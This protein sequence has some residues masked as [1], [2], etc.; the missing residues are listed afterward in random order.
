M[1]LRSNHLVCL[2]MLAKERPGWPSSVPG[3]EWV[4]CVLRSLCWDEQYKFY[5]GFNSLALPSTQ[6]SRRHLFI[7]VLTKEGR[8]SPALRARWT[9]HLV[10]LMSLSSVAGSPKPPLGQTCHL[11]H[12]ATLHHKNL[13]LE[14]FDSVTTGLTGLWHQGTELVKGM[15][16][17]SV[18]SSFCAS[19]KKACTAPRSHCSQLAQSDISVCRH[20][21]T[22][23]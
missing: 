13:G 10:L 23:F 3:S 18:S 21:Y 5:E 9:N 15:S 6:S 4:E 8:S 20:W 16:G 2:T 19:D 1:L 14:L 17:I 7:P 12:F 22:V 11:L